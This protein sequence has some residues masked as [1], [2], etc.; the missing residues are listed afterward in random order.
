MFNEKK[1]LNDAKKFGKLSVISET[2]QRCY[3]EDEDTEIYFTNLIN[4][5]D[6]F[7]MKNI[8]KHVIHLCGS[9][10]NEFFFNLSLPLQIGK[11]QSDLIC[12]SSF[13]HFN[14]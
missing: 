6:L 1:I 2:F 12:K 13:K 5:S 3:L 9:P 11:V 4:D 8:N 14:D 10:T 7:K